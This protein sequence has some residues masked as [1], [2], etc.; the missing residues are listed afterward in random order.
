M[1]MRRT[2]AL[3][4]TIL[5]IA[6]CGDAPRQDPAAARSA[7]NDAAKAM[8]SSFD[9]EMGGGA[10]GAP[11]RPT[12]K[13]TSATT[14]KPKPTAAEP[15]AGGP[16]VEHGRPAWVDQPPSED[17]RMYAVGGA[18]R[19][20]R[21]AAQVNAR[22]E[23]AKQL[24]VHVT[25]TDTSI[26][27]ETSR[28]G[29]GGQ[30]VSQAWSS[31]RTEASANV[32]RDLNATKIVAIA[33]DGK[34]TWALAMLDCVAWSSQLRQEIAGVDAKLA[35]ERDRM[36]AAGSG[37]RQA[38]QAMRAVGPLAAQREALIADL[39][40]ADPHGQIPPSPVDI[41]ALIQ[42]CAKQL[43]TVTIHLEGAPDAVFASRTQDAM[44]RLGLSVTEKAGTAVGLRLALR[45]TPRELPNKWHKF[46]V[47]GS[48]T[49]IDPVSGAITGSLQIEESGTDPDEG[50]ARSKMLDHASAALATAIN[51]QLLD[52]LGQ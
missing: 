13:P 12:S 35:A 29:A 10:N 31:Y 26:E 9:T 43:G 47:S 38:A 5:L 42:A 3:T 33:E 2:A 19:G 4:A 50:Q 20:Q 30:R 11:A 22:K 8:D 36:A 46:S 40:L 34:E 32:D 15:P 25:G 51:E 52:L 45:I 14:A 24:K 17:G 27:Q 1:T 21:D 16:A 41:M 18:P 28:L 7:H 49:V 6:G 39:I 23:L 37:L 48:A 44:A